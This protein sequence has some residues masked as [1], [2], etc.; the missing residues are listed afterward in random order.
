MARVRGVV[1]RGPARPALA[2]GV[3]LRPRIQT[4]HHL[5]HSMLRLLSQSQCRNICLRSRPIYPNVVC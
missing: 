1:E 2:Q 3:D 5:L 4:P